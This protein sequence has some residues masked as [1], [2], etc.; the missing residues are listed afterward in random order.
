MSG[1]R[2]AA[3]KARKQG[4]AGFV[5]WW[6][7]TGR[8]PVAK[9]FHADLIAKTM[10]FETVRWMGIEMRQ[11]VL[12][13]WTIQETITEVRPALLIETG[14]WD[15]GSALFYAQLMDLLGEGRVLTIDIDDKNE[16]D[17]PRVEFL[18]G[19][20]TAPETVEQVRAKVDEVD[21]PVM[22]ILDGDHSQS[23]VAEE[24]ELYAPLVTPGSFLLSQD[25]VI[26]EME[27]FR[28]SRPGPLPANRDFLARHPEFEHDA[29]RNERFLLTH[30]P[31]GWLKRVR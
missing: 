5:R 17:H 30:H 10:N 29:E 13:V 7:R 3:S 23:H 14:T 2:R 4:I 15:G 12:D 11:N 21:G 18:H 19:S 9:L 16:L 1:T 28:E 20:S 25:G 26:D 6:P 27:L 31:L 22:V 8:K 24:L